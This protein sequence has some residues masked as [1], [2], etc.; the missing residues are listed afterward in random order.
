MDNELDQM[1]IK[2][3]IKIKQLKKEI[4]NNKEI[5]N[6]YSFNGHR[7]NNENVDLKRENFLLKRKINE[8][9]KVILQFINVV[10]ESKYKLELLI[11]ENEQMKKENIML[12]KI[13]NNNSKNNKKESNF[14]EILENLKN[15][16]HIL[17]NKKDNNKQDDYTVNLEN[18]NE[19]K[20]S[21]QNKELIAQNKLYEEQINK[22]KNQIKLLTEKLN[23]V[24]NVSTTI[25]SNSC[26]LNS[27][28]R[29]LR[30][31][32]YSFTSDNICK[33][34]LNQTN[35]FPQSFTYEI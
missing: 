34:N 12:K 20:L 8:N 9:E 5:A 1:I 18:D 26:C 17:V 23:M 3:K 25:H 7:N 16:I 15:E 10:Q 19:I 32:N 30:G 6:E 4:A 13:L 11:K 33:N 22:M 24:Q 2:Q 27:K 29:N 28:S 21:N 14:E 31:I 35:H